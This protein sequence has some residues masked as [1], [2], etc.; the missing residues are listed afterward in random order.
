MKVRHMDGH[1]PKSWATKENQNNQ[2]VDQ[3]P[4]IEVAEV[5]LEWQDSQE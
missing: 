3:A 5:D 2:Q 1:V 4:K